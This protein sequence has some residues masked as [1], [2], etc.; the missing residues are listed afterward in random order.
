M[1]STPCDLDVGVVYTNERHY[2]E[3]LIATLSASARDLRVRLMLVDN[4]SAD[5]TRDWETAFDETLVIRNAT[6]LGYAENLNQIVARST[7]RY[8]LLLNTDMYFDVAEQC[9][10]KMWEFME[11]HPECGLSGCRLYHPDGSYAYPARRFQTLPIIAARRLGLGHVLP[12]TL[13]RY[14]Y[15]DHDVRDTF[16]CEWLSGCFMFARREALQQVGQFDLRF[17]KYFEDVD[18]SLRMAAAGWQVM[19]NGS[20]YGYHCEQRASTRLFSRDGW[21]HIR[22]YSRW[23]SKWGFNPRRHIARAR[24]TVDT[25]RRIAA[26]HRTDPAHAS[27]RSLHVPPPHAISNPDA[28]LS[29]SR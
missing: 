26:I 22:S 5:G 2:M 20:T 27:D 14:F 12:R 10:R 29:L 4:A 23:L 1:A 17:A 25:E 28:A 21:Q 16:E 9:V 13:H 7:A 18:L 8:V 24:S 19:F 11:S 3:P 6:Q 15:R